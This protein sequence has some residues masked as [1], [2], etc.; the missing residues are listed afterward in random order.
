[1]LSDIELLVGANAIVAQAEI[2]RAKSDLDAARPVL[3]RMKNSRE[4]LEDALEAV[5]E[6]GAHSTSSKTQRMLTDALDRI[7]QGL[8]AVEHLP[9]CVERSRRVFMPEAMFSTHRT[10]DGKRKIRKS[11]AVVAGGTLG[12]G[13]G[14]RRSSTC[15]MSHT[16]SG[17]I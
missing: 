8:P 13:I 1:M 2:V 3:E 6:Q 5:E 10:R 4:V 15:L 16:T 11:S 14:L 17:C 9:T 12:L 7:G